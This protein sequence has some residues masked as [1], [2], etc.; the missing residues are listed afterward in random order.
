MS[1]LLE[2]LLPGRGDAAA[3]RDVHF[4][5]VRRGSPIGAHRVTFRPDGRRLTVET[6]IDIAVKALFLTVF[7]FKHDAEEIWDSGRLVSVTS[8]TDDNGTLLK[9]AGTAVADGFR[10]VGADGPFLASGGLLTSNTLWDSRILGKARLIDVQRGG[11]IGL[12]T[13]PLGDEQ[14]ATPW[15]VVR[16]GRHRMITPHYAG[17]V[18]YDEDGRWVKAL[19]E[20]KGESIEYV[21]AA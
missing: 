3:P 1:P 6:H 4:R 5:A 19:L 13:T 2:S 21:L 8:T 7:R 10:I 11:E 9:V 18:S 14:L 15:G 16:A 12:V 17:S 20:V